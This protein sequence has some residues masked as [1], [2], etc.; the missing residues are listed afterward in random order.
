MFQERLPDGDVFHVS[1]LKLGTKAD[2]HWPVS[3]SPSASAGSVLELQLWWLFNQLGYTRSRVMQLELG[4]EC[5][6][7]RPAGPNAVLDV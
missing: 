5:D 7:L 4:R 2:D 1:T 6:L 3:T